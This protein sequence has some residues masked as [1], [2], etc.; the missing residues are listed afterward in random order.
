MKNAKKSMFITTILMVAVLV[1]AISTATFAWYTSTG[2]GTAS[3]ANLV[4]AESNAANVAVG[5]DANAKTTSVTFSSTAV[6]V[7]PMAPTA[8]PIADMTFAALELKTATLDA[9]GAF[10]ADGQT[11]IPWTVS[12]GAAQDAKTSFYVI[13]HNMNAG[14]TVNMTISYAANV[15][16]DNLDDGD[17]SITYTNNDKL[18]VAVFVEGKLAGIFTQL[19]EYKAGA[20]VGGQV[21]SDLDGTNA[22]IKST[23]AIELDAAPSATEGTAKNIQIKAWLDGGALTQS[24]AAQPAAFSFNFEAAQ[25]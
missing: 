2:N 1:V 3:Q 25:A 14:V 17:D 7:A 20:I 21:A 8:E 18:V 19:S 12:D 11:A 23:I 13:N 24:Y 4:A 6:E 9:T 5:W 15:V 22:L 16:D 10:N